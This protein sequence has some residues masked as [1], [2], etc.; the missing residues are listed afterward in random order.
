MCTWKIFSMTN[1]NEAV[2]K[3]NNHVMNTPD[4]PTTRGDKLLKLRRT[5]PWDLTEP[6]LSRGAVLK[7]E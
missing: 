7:T 3:K 1:Y 5:R 4:I 6:K 2:I